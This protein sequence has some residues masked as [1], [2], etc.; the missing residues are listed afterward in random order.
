MLSVYSIQLSH[1]RAMYRMVHGR[2]VSH[3]PPA[4][5][6][7]FPIV[8]L[9]DLTRLY[10]QFRNGDELEVDFETGRLVL[11][12]ERTFQ[13]APFSQVQMDIYRAGDLFAYGQTLDKT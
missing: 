7:G 13:A 4:I 11:N 2:A 9:P 12:G 5:N 8:V 6:S 10:G 1:S 3:P